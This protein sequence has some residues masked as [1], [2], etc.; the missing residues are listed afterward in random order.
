[1]EIE[2]REVHPTVALLFFESRV[3]CERM[4]VSVLED[5]ITSRMKDVARENLVRQGLNAFQGIRRI[6]EYD[7]ELLMTDIQE[8]EHIVPYHRD[9]VKPQALGLGLDKRSVLPG[10]LD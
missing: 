9:I 4:L 8:V 1:M 10:H 7:V 6:S 3:V 2:E 5:E